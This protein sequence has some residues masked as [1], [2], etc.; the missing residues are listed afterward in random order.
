MDRPVSREARRRR[1]AASL[2]VP[3]WARPSVL[4][5]VFGGYDPHAGDPAAADDR[6]RAEQ[7]IAD[8]VARGV[9]ARDIAGLDTPVHE[10][11]EFDDAHFVRDVVG[12]CDVHVVL[13][14][15][16]L[17]PAVPWELTSCRWVDV[18]IQHAADANVPQLGVRVH[19]LPGL[20]GSTTAAGSDPFD[21]HFD[22]PWY[23]PGP[24]HVYDYVEDNGPDNLLR[25]IDQVISSGEHPRNR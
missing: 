4:V 18:A 12:L 3:S 16:H 2:S 10:L 13:I 23:L 19:G 6:H 5:S 14:T 1:A 22:D 17:E 8:Q 15:G 24:A 21:G 7:V 25:W 20:D 11:P 9:P